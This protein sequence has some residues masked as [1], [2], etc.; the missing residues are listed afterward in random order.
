MAIT[1]NVP[2]CCYPVWKECKVSNMHSLEGRGMCGWCYRQAKTPRGRR[3]NP[4]RGTGLGLGGSIRRL[5]FLSHLTPL[6]PTNLA[7]WHRREMW[8]VRY[9]CR[10]PTSHP[11]WLPVGFGPTLVQTWCAFRFTEHEW[12]LEHEHVSINEI[13]MILCNV[14]KNSF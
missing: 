5:S 3:D 9:N 6:N 7:K 2:L 4:A 11:A 12:T 13:W 1:P 10:K 14:L 8:F